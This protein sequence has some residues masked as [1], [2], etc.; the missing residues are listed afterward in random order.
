MELRAG[1]SRGPLDGVVVADFSRVLAGPLAA[2]MLGDLGA[3]VIKIERPGLGDDTRSWG[4]PFAEDGSATYYLSVNRNKRSV[5]LDLTDEEQ[6]AQARALAASADVVVENFRAGTMER[7]GL[8]YE[9]LRADNPGLVFCRVSAFGP[10][11]GRALP[12][13]DFIVQAASGFMSI[14]GEAE[15]TPTKTGV[16]IVDVVTGLYAT[17]GIVA[18]L[19]ERETSG[20]GQFIEVNLLSSA[21]AALIN[22]SSAFVSGGVV[23]GRMGNLHPSITPYETFATA[24]DP[25]AIAATNERQFS[26]LC[27]SL[28]A[29]HLLADERWSTNTTRVE[30]REALAAELES[31]LRHKPCD[32]WVERLTEYGIP[33]SPV[34]SIDAAFALAAEL[35]LNPV[36]HIPSSDGRQQATV[37]N[38]ITFSR[39]PTSHRLAPPDLG[40]DTADVLERL[41]S[42]KEL[43]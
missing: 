8:D 40:A 26:S 11:G 37:A 34:N 36:R 28:D 39:T 35:G 42:P 15:G 10:E 18:A 6:R 31:I 23:P 19:A 41:R 4:P 22:Q 16:A 3:E 30:H 29:P 38:P 1:A 17:V 33:C 27:K 20:V 7:F 14:T 24:T 13:Y 43:P 9:S 12:G 25:I 2:M 21:L 32:H 5:T